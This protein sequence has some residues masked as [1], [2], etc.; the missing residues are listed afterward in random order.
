MATA[1]ASAVAS[2]ASQITASSGCPGASAS[3]RRASRNGVPVGDSITIPP[4][5][6]ELQLVQHPQQRAGLL[7][8]DV[9]LDQVAVRLADHTLSGS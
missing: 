9:A 7:A 5:S 2:T 6:V 3:S 8:G 4:R 1:P